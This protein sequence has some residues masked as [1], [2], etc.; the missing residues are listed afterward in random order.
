VREE[1]MGVRDFI[2]SVV[3]T[4]KLARKSGSDEFMQYLKLVFLGL[5]VVGAIGFVIQFVGA[6]LRLG[7]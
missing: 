2:R 5:A 1:R 6:L 7:R 3:N 4:L